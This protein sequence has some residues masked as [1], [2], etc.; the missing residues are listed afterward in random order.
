MGEDSCQ[1]VPASVSTVSVAKKVEILQSCLLVCD[2]YHVRHMAV[3]GYRRGK[4]SSYCCQLSDKQRQ[5]AVPAMTTLM[6]KRT[7]LLVGSHVLCLSGLKKMMMLI[8]NFNFT[9][10]IRCLTGPAYRKPSV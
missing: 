8:I 4:M 6:K 7:L 1:V 5:A 9:S 3:E 10:L 2:G